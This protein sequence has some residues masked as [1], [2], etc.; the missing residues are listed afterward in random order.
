MNKTIEKCKKISK[1][2]KIKKYNSQI[3]FAINNMT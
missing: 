3:M 1:Y 2:T